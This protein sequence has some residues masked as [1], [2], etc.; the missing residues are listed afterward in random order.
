MRVVLQGAFAVASNRI[1]SPCCRHDAR[2][3]SIGRGVL[4]V[5]VRCGT[6]EDDKAL[7]AVFGVEKGA[8]GESRHLGT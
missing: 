5:L 4:C 8:R 3:S 2:F 1:S 7:E 6:S